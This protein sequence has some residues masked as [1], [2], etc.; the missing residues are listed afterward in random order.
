MSVVSKAIVE[1][2]PT[3]R[4]LLI[5]GRRDDFIPILSNV[6]SRDRGTLSEIDGDQIWPEALAT[7]QRRS[8]RRAE[9]P[10]SPVKS[11]ALHAACQVVAP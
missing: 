1:T 9:T 10:L 6:I 2:G 3:F 5:G 4:S 11:L 8:A 7:M